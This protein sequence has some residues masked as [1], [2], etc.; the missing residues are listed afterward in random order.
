MGARAFHVPDH[1][2]SGTHSAVD[3]SITPSTGLSRTRGDVN[4][5]APSVRAARLFAA[6]LDAAKLSYAETGDILGGVTPQRVAAKCHPLRPDA[7]PTIADLLALLDGGKSS[8]IESVIRYLQAE[9]DTA[10]CR[11]SG[12]RPA[13]VSLV[14]LQFCARASEAAE[15]A[16][17]AVSENEITDA[18]AARVLERIA[19][20][21]K[22]LGSLQRS[23]VRTRRVSR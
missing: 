7:P 16:N 20:A 1:A 11:T 8:A 23:V 4:E 10:D 19:A 15:A 3:G 21:G 12:V 6:A 13:A 14:A 22:A 17:D 18:D 2:S 9:L 5:M